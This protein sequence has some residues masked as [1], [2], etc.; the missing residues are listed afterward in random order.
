MNRVTEA[1]NRFLNHLMAKTNCC[2][3]VH[4]R[5]CKTGRRLQAIYQARYWA[6]YVMKGTGKAARNSRLLS[7]PS[8]C[9]RHVRRMVMVLFYRE[10]AES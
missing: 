4:G 7:V 2:A 3:A 5:Y 1:H 10:K 9:R 8:N 6:D